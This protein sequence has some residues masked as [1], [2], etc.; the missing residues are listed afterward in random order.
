MIAAYDGMGLTDLADQSRAVYALNFP[1]GR[2]KRK[3]KRWY[4]F[5]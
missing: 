4:Q 3:P 2:L 1:D 5:W